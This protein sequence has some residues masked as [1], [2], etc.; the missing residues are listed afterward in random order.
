MNAKE[1][2]QK[3]D[4]SR[5]TLEKFITYAEMLDKWQKSINLV[6][7]TTLSDKWLRHFYDSAQLMEMIEPDENRKILDLGS[8]AGFPGL[9]ISLMGAGEV[10]LVEGVGKKCSFMKQVVRATGMNAIVHNERIE[11]MDPFT[12]D[13]ITSRAC[14]DL[15]KLLDLTSAFIGEKTQCLFLKGEKADQE[16]SDAQKKWQFD[17]KKTAS[18]SEESGIILELSNIKRK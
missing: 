17:V 3:T 4:V 18:K 8:G 15:E 9:V 1:F 13:L 11:Q 2:Q 14:A 5:E 6:S 16:I 10:H 7:N 12:V